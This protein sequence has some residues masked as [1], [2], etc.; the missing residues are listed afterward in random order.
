MTEKIF[1]SHAHLDD[2]A[3]D[4][5]REDILSVCAENLAGVLNPGTDLASSE[6]AAALAARRANIYAAAGFHPHE[7]RLMKDGDEE[8]LAALAKQEKV[9]AIGEI[10]LDYYYD[11]SP[12]P[13]QQDVFARQLDLAR[14]LA[15]PVIIHDR[16]AHDDA[17]AIISRAG[18]GLRG[19]FHCYAGDWAMA[20][21]LLGKGFYLSFGGSLTFKTAGQT[22]EVAQKTPLDRI[23]LETDSPYL[24]PV[25]LRGRRNDP[26]LITHVCQKLAELRGRSFDEIARVT[27]ANAGELFRLS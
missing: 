11:H 22:R 13:I 7:A 5:D 20:R 15:L 3:F 14:Q 24:T 27:A 17:L 10:G 26:R 4:A 23:L 16:E 9:V 19:V 1:D 6:K 21:L 2:E 18:N 25:P 12:R 8:R